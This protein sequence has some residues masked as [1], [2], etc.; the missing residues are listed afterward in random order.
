MGQLAP[1]SGAAPGTHF[2]QKP[3]SQMCAAPLQS[4]ACAHWTHRSAA[5]LQIS[6]PMVVHI[7]SL[8]H[9]ARHMN[10]RWSQM[11]VVVPQSEFARQATHA[12][13]AT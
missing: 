13:V 8:V 4:E 11:G 3:T 2:T 1:A 5:V 6:V 7:A 12:C 10:V 9:P